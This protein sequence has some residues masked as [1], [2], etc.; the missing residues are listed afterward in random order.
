MS[1]PA[2]FPCRLIQRMLK[3][4][5]AGATPREPPWYLLVHLMLSCEAGVAEQLRDEPSGLTALHAFAFYGKAEYVRLLIA[6]GASIAQRDAQGNTALHMAVCGDAGRDSNLDAIAA[7]LE[8]GAEVEVAARAATLP[9]FCAISSQSAE[10][11]RLLLRHGADV[12]GCVE[13]QGGRRGSRSPL[14]LA[15]QRGHVAIALDLVRLGGA[16]LERDRSQPTL[17]ERCRTHFD[18]AAVACWHRVLDAWE[19]RAAE[20]RAVHFR[21]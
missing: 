5:C 21:R 18:V 15:V 16:T 8:H 3:E 12:H 4:M 9:L 1:L 2:P 7:L 6:R 14:C 11:V 19:Q 17:A 13:N 10:T 20:R